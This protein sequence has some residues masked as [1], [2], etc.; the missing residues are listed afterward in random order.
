MS[1][2]YKRLKDNIKDN[3]Y[4]EDKLGNLTEYI[5]RTIRIDDRNYV[6]YIKKRDQRLPTLK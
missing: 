5:Q 2:F 1:R 4:K 3:L 6:R